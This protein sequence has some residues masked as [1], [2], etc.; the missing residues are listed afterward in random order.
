MTEQT[1]DVQFIDSI[2]LCPIASWQQLLDKEN[3]DY[4][5]IQYAF[6]AALEDSESCC[7]K[8]GWQAKHCLVYD[9]E[10]LVALMPCYEKH[11]SYGEYVFDH[12]WASAYHQ[13][14][15]N[16]Y[17]KLLTAIPFTPCQ[18]PR[19]VIDSN[20][21]K[22]K[23]EVLILE[24][25]KKLCKQQNYSGW[26]GLF[27]ENEQSFANLPA[28][29]GVQ[30]HWYNRGYQNFDEFLAAFTSRKRKMVKK[31]RKKVQEQGFRCRFVEGENI[32]DHLWQQFHYLYQ[33]TY[34]KRSGHGGYLSQT[35]FTELGR[36]LADSVVL[37]VAE[38]EEE[39]S[40]SGYRLCAASLFFKDAETLYGRYWGCYTEFD[41]LHF[42]ACY[43]QAIDYCISHGLTHIDAG[44]QG[45]HKVQRGFEPIFTSSVHYLQHP[46]FY[47]AISQV[48]E[49][50]KVHIKQY[51]QS[52]WQALP[53]Q[54]GFLK[55]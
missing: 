9:D 3:I 19:L 40:E 43:Y 23:V 38:L 1:L 46:G 20:Y 32:D 50:E 34:A 8:T 30:F 26:H 10:K 28:R 27:L 42:E 7:L 52:C 55:T 4:P 37:L 16:Y 17:P 25:M 54:E 14:G 15:L 18:G 21:D 44:A 45:E 35:F 2:H 47:Q 29:I 39:D 33:L 12:Q 31:E 49:E 22:T 13:H 11:H 6:I 36:N 51:H 5:F 41:F 24:T 48:V 53:Y